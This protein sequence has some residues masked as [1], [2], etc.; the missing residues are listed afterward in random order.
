MSRY[1]RSI[2][3]VQQVAPALDPDA[4]AF[5]LAASITDATITDAINNLVLSLKS[6]SIWTK[7]I[8]LYPLVGGTASTH[9]F[10]LKDPVDSDAAFRLTFV[11][12]PTHS[13]DG[14][15]GNGSS[16]YANTHLNTSTNLTTN[17]LLMDVHF[18]DQPNT[19]NNAV[20][21][22]NITS[23]GANSNAF[24][25]TNTP[26][27]NS[28]RLFS[29]GA[30]NATTVTKSILVGRDGNNIFRYV[31]DSFTDNATEAS[32]TRL[33]LDLFIL[34]SNLS[35]SPTN[36]SN[37]GL[38]FVTIGQDFTSAQAATYISLRNTF[39]TAIGR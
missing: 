9:K 16:Q 2:L 38:N 33:N 25:L 29:N 14:M 31:N 36:Y 19:I 24:I 12:S 1:Y 21:I 8:A 15:Q 22:G 18:F 20:Q 6:D 27:G 7:M 30:F 13:S 17:N 28:R 39:L 37:G 35:G 3:N 32:G 10:N 4:E 23:P 5:L 34:A 11:G 26:N